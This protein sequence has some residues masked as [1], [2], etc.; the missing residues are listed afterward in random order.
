MSLAQIQLLRVSLS[1]LVNFSVK[2]KWN[3]Q[4]LKSYLLLFKFNVLFVWL[5]TITLLNSP[6]FPIMHVSQKATYFFQ[7]SF[8]HVC[9]RSCRLV[10][11]G[12]STDIARNLINF[13][14]LKKISNIL[15]TYPSLHDTG[16]R[17]YIVYRHV[18]RNTSIFVTC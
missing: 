13:F 11:Q 8:F 12:I 16:Y 6:Q 9:T 4:I 5:N 18:F 14:F 3:C 17:M 1:I 10:I 15:P 7:T 2:I